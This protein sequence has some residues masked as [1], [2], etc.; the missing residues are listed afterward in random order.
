[1]P[2]SVPPADRIAQRVAAA[3]AAENEPLRTT[4]DVL[5]T[6][7]DSYPR[8]APEATILRAACNIA[9]MRTVELAVA[10]EAEHSV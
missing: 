4:V 2:S 9:A 8:D 3:A 5:K 1:M 7:A 6:L 10:D